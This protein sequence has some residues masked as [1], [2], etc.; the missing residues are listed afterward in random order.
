MY[1]AREV[2]P[3]ET[4]FCT[5]AVGVEG[6]GRELKAMVAKNGAVDDVIVSQTDEGP[7]RR[8]KKYLTS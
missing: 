4:G 2:H 6:C 1:E 8:W 7:P 5:A 3:V